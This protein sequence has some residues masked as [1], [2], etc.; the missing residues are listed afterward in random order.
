MQYLISL[1]S[2]KGDRAGFLHQARHA[3][4][5]TSGKMTAISGIYETKPKGFESP[6]MFY[7]QVIVLESMLRP[8]DLIIEVLKTEGLMGRRRNIEGVYESREIDLDILLA[9]Q[10]VVQGDKLI[11]PHPRM[12]LRGF[13]LVPACEIASGWVH[14]LLN[15]TLMSLCDE[16][17]EEEKAIVRV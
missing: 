2:N 3:L 12:H 5:R 4:E 6:D 14:P 1:G 8:E 13:V 7:N 17:S 15:K 11:I 10:L 9:E 16:L